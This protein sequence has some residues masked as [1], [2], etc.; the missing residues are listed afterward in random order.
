MDVALTLGALIVLSPMLLLIALIIRL[1]SLGP[2]LYRQTRNGQNGRE[3]VM[4]KFRTLRIEICA[5]PDGLFRQITAD[6]P[7]VTRVGRFLRWTS[8]DE[9][10]QLVNVLRGEMSIAGPRPHP[11]TLNEQYV[12]RIDRYRMRHAVEP[13]ITGWAQ[14]N[15]LRGETD[16]LE[17]ME[18]RV[19]YDL[20]YIEH[21][22]LIFDLRVI[23]QT[24][25]LGFLDRGTPKDAIPKSGV[26]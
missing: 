9:L 4:L 22:S 24:L 5:S 7:R 17:K 10:P 15:G 3:F 1:D 21:W 18:R 16:T 12:E 14:I 23:A 2:A 19:H 8:L 20:Y 11:V 6:D 26:R 13:G 25:R